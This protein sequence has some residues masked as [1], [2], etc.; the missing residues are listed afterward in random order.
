MNIKPFL[1]LLLLMFAMNLKSKTDFIASFNMPEMKIYQKEKGKQVIY[2]FDDESNKLTV[3]S[4][5]LIADTNTYKYSVSLSDI[6]KI[7]I[8]NGTHF[9]GAA[10]GVGAFGFVLGF[11]AGA[12]FT[13]GDGTPKFNIGEA[14]VG[15]ALF[16]IP[17]GLIGGLFGLLFPNYDEYNIYN[18]KESKY[19]RLIKIFKR[20][21]L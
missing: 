7:A 12:Y 2:K 11:F 17:F 1:I 10:A 15:G 19:Q 21:K 16:A 6:S 9:W 5:Q 3:T 13:L 18:T 8:R 4:N 20:N 14:L